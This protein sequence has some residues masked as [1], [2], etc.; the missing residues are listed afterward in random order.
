[1]W[2]NKLTKL[3]FGVSIS[4]VLLALGMFVYVLFQNDGFVLGLSFIGVCIFT[5][6]AFIDIQAVRSAQKGKA[7]LAIA[8]VLFWIY[9]IFSV[10]TS[11]D[12][13]WQSRLMGY[14]FSTITIF[15]IVVLALHIRNKGKSENNEYIIVPAE[16]QK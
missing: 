3:Y 4:G 10:L 11:T 12:L 9:A 13:Q 5:F 7:G 8:V 1:M 2:I 15:K 14:V 16:Q 6:V